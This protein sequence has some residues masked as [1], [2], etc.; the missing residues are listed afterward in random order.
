MH[1]QFN[2]KDLLACPITN[3]KWFDV[4]P[5]EVWLQCGAL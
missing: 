3:S 4:D 1:T 2:C 5:H